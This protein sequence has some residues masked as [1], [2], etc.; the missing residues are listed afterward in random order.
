MAYMI[1]VKNSQICTYAYDEGEVYINKA[2]T[3]DLLT[4]SAPN[5]LTLDYD[6]FKNII[7][8]SEKI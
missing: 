1:K 4:G 2:N 3:I 8:S 5:Y 7:L 6:V